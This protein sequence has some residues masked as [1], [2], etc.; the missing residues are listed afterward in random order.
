MIGTSRETLT[1][2]LGELRATGAVDVRDR[3]IW[4]LDPRALEAASAMA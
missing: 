3:Q 2:A 4:V 1:K